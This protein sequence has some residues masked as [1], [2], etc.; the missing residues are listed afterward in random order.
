MLP[1]QT[2]AVTD[3]DHHAARQFSPQPKQNQPCQ[4]GRQHKG[5]NQRHNSSPSPIQITKL[6]LFSYVTKLAILTLC[7]RN[8]REVYFAS[9]WP[10]P[11]LPPQA[12]L[13]FERSGPAR[14]ETGTSARTR[15][16][17]RHLLLCRARRPHPAG[18]ETGVCGMTRG[19]ILLELNVSHSKCRVRPCRAR[20]HLLHIYRHEREPPTT[21][22]LSKSNHFLRLPNRPP[23]RIRY[24]S[25]GSRPFTASCCCTR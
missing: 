1:T 15:V 6:I 23:K 14:N 2:A 7:L 11:Q 24:A 21:L 5:E 12:S 8:A 25:S 19:T 18:T 10:P 16:I 22:C 3:H 4:E 17:I 20:P 13:F 9:F